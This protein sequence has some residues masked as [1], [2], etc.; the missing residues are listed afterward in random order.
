MN[1]LFVGKWD[2]AGA[3][4]ADRLL[5]EGNEVCWMTGE[6]KESL[7]NSSFKG[8][9]YRGSWKREDYLRILKANSVDTVV[10]LTG[11][12][13][14]HY[15]EVYEYES[16]MDGLTNLMGVLRNYP[17]KCFLYLSS[18]ELDY[19]GG[20]TPLLADLAAGETLCKAYQSTCKMPVLILRIGCVYGN[21][22][23]DQMGYTGHV[24]EEMYQNSQIHSLY[25]PEDMLD[26][27]YGGDLAMAVYKMLLLECRG[28]YKL[29]TGHPVTMEAYFGC[30]E[31][32]AG[33]RPKIVWEKFRH[34]AP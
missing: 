4:I 10:F 24:L 20:Y 13:R 12:L 8:N 22:K 28:T 32:A 21:A 27:I 30:L 7:W 29:M 5:Q 1:V 3:Y 34:T 11:E 6:D 25:S 31:K 19:K 26:V 17:L 33:I 2:I 9:I 18:L 16:Q 23:L 15:E 14:E